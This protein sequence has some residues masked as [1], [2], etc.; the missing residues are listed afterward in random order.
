MSDMTEY[1]NHISAPGFDEDC[2]SRCAPVAYALVVDAAG[3]CPQ[4]E[5][6]EQVNVL[7]LDFLC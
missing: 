1:E 2:P 3:H 5:Q 6:A 7:L 4:I